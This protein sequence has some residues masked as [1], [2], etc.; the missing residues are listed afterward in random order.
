MV[1]PAA[2]DEAGAICNVNADDAAAALAGALQA[3]LVLLTDADGVWG[4]DRQRI[5]SLTVEASEQL[6]DAGV[7]AGGMVP[8]VRCAL[9]AIDGGLARSSSPTAGRPMRWAGHSTTPASAP[10]GTPEPGLSRA[11]SGPSRALVG[12]ESPLVG[13]ESPLV[14]P[15]SPGA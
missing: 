2:L 6:I 14:G 4:A 13:P 11:W 3:R 8:K 5:L 12:P 10:A 7:I 1:A 15:E 9:R